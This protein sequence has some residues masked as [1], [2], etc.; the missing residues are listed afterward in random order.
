MVTRD[1]MIIS[2]QMMLPSLFILNGTEG[3]LV[4]LTW[5]EFCCYMHNHVHTR[6]FDVWNRYYKYTIVRLVQIAPLG[7]AYYGI[8]ETC[9]GTCAKY[10]M[11]NTI[12]RYG[13]GCGLVISFIGS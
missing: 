13:L 5:L 6:I 10:I 4:L 12:S 9:L 7:V 3:N 11:N 8:S 1:S 2:I